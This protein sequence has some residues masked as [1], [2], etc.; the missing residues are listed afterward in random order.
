MFAMDLIERLE[1][2]FRDL[3]ELIIR[4][5]S[6]FNLLKTDIDELIE[7]FDED[8]L[9]Y[10]SLLKTIFENYLTFYQI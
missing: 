7:T 8:F 5:G 10:G 6:R 3:E 9:G 4:R 1:K 2:W